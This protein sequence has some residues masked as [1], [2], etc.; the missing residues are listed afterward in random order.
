MHGQIEQVY[1]A[2]VEAAAAL[3]D[4]YASSGLALEISCTRR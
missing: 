1:T 3:A 4:R 2:D